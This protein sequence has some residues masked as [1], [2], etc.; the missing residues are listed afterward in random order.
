MSFAE[1]PQ[2]RDS[3]ADMSRDLVTRQLPTIDVARLPVDRVERGLNAIVVEGEL[4][5]DNCEICGASNAPLI[6]DPFQVG[7]NN[8]EVKMRL[9]SSC[10]QI[11]TDDI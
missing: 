5:E 4:V 7:V 10:E 2:P 3:Q 8:E 6:T 1:G 9:C 11:R